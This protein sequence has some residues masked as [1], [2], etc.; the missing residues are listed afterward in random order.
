MDFSLP[1][2][3]F[4][5]VLIMF[6]M[7]CLRAH[8]E[9]W[10]FTSCIQ[11]KYDYSGF[12]L[13]HRLPVMFIFYNTKLWQ[14]FEK[15]EAT[16]TYC[17]FSTIK[18]QHCN[19]RS[20]LSASFLGTGEGNVS[21]PLTGIRLFRPLH[22]PTEQWVKICSRNWWER[23]VSMEFNAYYSLYI[24]VRDILKFVFVLLI[25]H[26]AEAAQVSWQLPASG[27]RRIHATASRFLPEFSN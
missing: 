13:L 8:G 4:S 22:K 12:W 10:I 11:D 5:P 20:G 3:S 9:I 19:F 26:L 24:T 7:W 15:N 23:V 16:Q 25:C 1:A 18:Y 17:G 6:R 21:S 2:M 27:K 14:F